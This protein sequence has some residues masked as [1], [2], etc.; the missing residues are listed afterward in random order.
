MVTWRTPSAIG[1][2][3]AVSGLTVEG[4]RVRAEATASSNLPTS[5]SKLAAIH[6]HPQDQL[7]TITVM[8]AHRSQMDSAMDLVTAVGPG[9][10]ARRTMTPMQL[11][12]AKS[13]T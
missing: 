12:D 2:H 4:V 11:A 1:V 10:V 3:K 5:S 9:P 6:L 13:A 8:L 7:T